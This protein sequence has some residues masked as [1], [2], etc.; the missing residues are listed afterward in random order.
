MFGYS[1]QVCNTDYDVVVVSIDG[2]GNL[3][4]AAHLKYQRL[5]E[6]VIAQCNSTT[7]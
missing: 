1:I 4:Y 7:Q 5:A 6:D 3:L 2:I